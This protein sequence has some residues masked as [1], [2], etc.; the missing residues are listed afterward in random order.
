M[1]GFEEPESSVLVKRHVS[2][3]EFDFECEAV[4]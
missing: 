2:L 3:G 1:S 4:V